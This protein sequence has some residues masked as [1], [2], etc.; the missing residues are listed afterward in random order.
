VRLARAFWVTGKGVGEIRTESLDDPGP[1]RILV[2]SLYSA[3]S[4]G[5]ESLVF[6]N[7]VPTSQ[8]RAMRA[9]HQAGEFPAP[10]K[11]GYTN[12]GRVVAGGSGAL[13]GRTVFCLYPHQDFYIVSEDAVSLVPE[14]VPA[15]RAVLAANMET[16]INA[17]WDSTPRVGAC[18][19]VVGAGVVGCLAAYLTSRTPG[20]RVQLVD[21]DGAKAAVAAA[22]GIP[23]AKP[24]EVQGDADLVIHASGAPAGLATSLLLA[25][26]EATVLEMSWYGDQH[27]P[28]PLGEAFHSRRLVLKSTQ[29]GSIA[30]AMRP[31][32]S[33][34]QRMALALSLLKD[35]ALDCLF[36]GES[37]FEELPETMAWL[38]Q[39]PNGA[40]C[41]RIRYSEEGEQDV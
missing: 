23:F 17:L 22:L 14:G 7:Q 12:V 18:V 10:V 5:T 21:T 9:P 19:A 2:R 40:L 15:A 36:T 11:Y 29:V 4:R 25:G 38:S 30:P 27:V 33:Y 26:V 8:Y 31:R 13:V 41:Q 28:L 24:E 39:K 32:W 34:G 16:A 1:G 6:R 35:D 3:V 20:C 37:R